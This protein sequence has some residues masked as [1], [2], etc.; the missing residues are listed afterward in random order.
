MSV[1]L[2]AGG[3]GLGTMWGKEQALD[4]LVLAGFSQVRVHELPH[5]IQNYYYVAH[6][7]R[8]R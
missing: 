3:A 2:A 7:P 5:D 1:S 6:K 8:R 4:M